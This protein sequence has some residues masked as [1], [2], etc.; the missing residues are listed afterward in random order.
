MAIPCSHYHIAYNKIHPDY[1]ITISE[2]IKPVLEI[3][4]Q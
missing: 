2:I 3:F 1:D 4:Y